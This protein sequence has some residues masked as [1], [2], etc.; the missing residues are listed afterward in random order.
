M[1]QEPRGRRGIK[2]R[3]YTESNSI[4]YNTQIARDAKID[5]IGHS[6]W[7]S[8]LSVPTRTRRHTPPVTID[9]DDKG[10]EA[11]SHN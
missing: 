7:D 3:V 10:A 6:I 5:T 9:E 8:I 11:P 2:I 4:R 1:S